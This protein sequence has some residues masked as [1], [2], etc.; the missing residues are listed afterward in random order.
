MTAT[1]SDKRAKKAKKRFI[2]LHNHTDNSLLDGHATIDAYVNRATEAGMS[3]L[4]VM[5]HGNL[6]GTP[7]FYRAC[8][9]AGIT[10][11]LAQEFYFAP[12][13][14]TY[15]DQK[16]ERFHV[17]II[18][19]NEAGFRT[20]VW[21][22]TE[23]HKNFYGKPVIDRKI[24]K[25]IPKKERKN[26]VVLSGCAASI[27]SRKLLGTE[28][29]SADD[30][31]LWWKKT[32]PHFYIE[33]MHHDTAFDVQLNTL[34]I[35]L[36]KKHGIPWVITNDPHYAEKA[37]A[38]HH[39]NLLAIQ[40][41]SDVDDPERF[42]FDGK[43]YWLK[44]PKEM[45]RTWKGY[46]DSIV[47]PGME[48][49]VRIAETCGIRIPSWESK[50]WH[51]PRYPFVEDA[52]A[53][54]ER[55]VK[56][57]LKEKELGKDYKKQAKKELKAFATV[58]T[59]NGAGMSDFLLY[60]RDAIEKAKELG[61]P[62]G[63]GRGSVCGTTVGYLIGLHKVDPIRYDLL[64]ERFFNPERPKMPDV[65][66]DYGK[67]RR[68]EVLD[69]YP[70]RYGAENTM[71]VAAFGTMQG[72]RAF[73]SM[74]KAHGIDFK[75]RIRLSQK[76]KEDEEGN[77]VWPQE[78]QD[79][80]PELMDEVEALLGR[81]SSLSSHPA[82]VVIFDPEDPIREL[83]PEMWIP[84]RQGKEGR[85]VMQF[86]LAATE[87]L[88]LLKQ[89]NLGLRTLD[90]IDE[91]VRMVEE[92]HGVK[93]DPDSWIP[94]EEPE[95]KN[96][97]KM[98]ARGETAGV[99]Q[100]E[101][102]TNHRGIQEIKPT[103]FEDIVTCTSLYRAGPMIAG[104]P[105][106][107]LENRK[108]KKVR[109]AHKSLKKIL[110][111][112]WGEMIYQEQMFA[113][114]NEAAGLSWSRVDDVKTA[115]SKKNAKMMAECKA[116]AVE[117]FQ[118]VSGMSEAEAEAVWA[119]IASQ[120]AYLFNRSHAVAYSIVTYQ[121]ARLRYLYPQEFYAALMRTVEPKSPADKAK[122]EGYLLDAVSKGYRI[123]PPDINSG[124]AGFTPE[125][126][127]IL[128]FG[129]TDISGIKAAAMT[130]IDK[131]IEERTKEKGKRPKKPFRS[132]DDLAKCLN[133]RD[134]TIGAFAALANAGALSQLGVPAV[135]AE[136]ERLLNFQF[137]DHM[138]EYRE[139]FK[140]K[141]KLPKGNNSR[142]LVYGQI[143][144]TEKRST[145]NNRT[146]Y[147][148]TIRWAPGAEYNVNVW[149]DASEFFRLQKGSIVRVRGNWNESWS[150]ISVSDPRQI[151]VF[152]TVTAEKPKKEKKAA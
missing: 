129:L 43:G 34:L 112:S 64:F 142:C 108:D 38:K 66:T 90:T 44:T 119:M 46:S 114:L 33:I 60:T 6:C 104:A 56:K 29:G 130:K 25:Q 49:S 84:K 8:T 122:R 51:I 41:G 141:V 131:W 11:V 148:W 20:L 92:R 140:D 94:D 78:I 28:P 16:G 124:E 132:P 48:E 86:N 151:K 71:P 70:E 54:V 36:A 62:V 128:R 7:E 32:F 82:G 126:D 14:E 13:N 65:D 120:S 61:I 134:R 23:G 88:F 95:D 73:Q 19:K 39:D 47:V 107:F 144:K 136:Q 2:H 137:N 99:F 139:R 116:D 37:H 40:T 133:T 81:K 93:L 87:A 3:H 123:L 5:D 4:A 121:T 1:I 103:Q 101:G 50:S 10:P 55:L 91:C 30:E 143:V 42:K 146:F 83:V 77:I 117:G 110:A 150:N 102:G 106:R 68:Q 45:A 115:T 9:A 26:L 125:G 80:Y 35:K 105:K 72:R 27:I 12:D 69:Y 31:V 89:D 63:P 75:L 59:P 52:A 79:D 147:V 15:R 145:K 152:K 100:M 135:E 67:A 57:G 24:I 18:A 22:S 97:Y 85:F 118:K 127:D 53:E 113:I 98:L 21:L 111:R 74:A 96:I 17:G 58:T 76:M 109:V 149:E 138:A